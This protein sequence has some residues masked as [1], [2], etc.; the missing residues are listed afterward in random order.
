MSYCDSGPPS[1]AYIYDADICP[2]FYLAIIIMADP[3]YPLTPF[4]RV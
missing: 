1:P 2:V 3:E 4:S